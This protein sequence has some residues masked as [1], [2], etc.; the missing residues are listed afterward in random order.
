M[1]SSHAVSFV[2][3]A[4]CSSA[5]SDERRSA[6]VEGACG[7]VGAWSGCARGARGTGE[8][9]VPGGS[10]PRCAFVRCAG[11]RW[12]WTVTGVAVLE[13]AVEDIDCEDVEADAG[14]SRATVRN[15]AVF[16]PF[17]GCGMRGVAVW[18]D[19]LEEEEADEVD[20]AGETE[21]EDGGEGS[22]MDCEML[23]GVGCRCVAMAWACKLRSD[24]IMYWN[25]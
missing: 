6:S 5:S 3:L 21:R 18:V 23:C 10:V 16:V 7:G 19:V 13:V 25:V 2:L 17:L 12:R 1:N 14:V 22:V 20:R 11:E 8:S 24:V 15:R 4:L 9:C